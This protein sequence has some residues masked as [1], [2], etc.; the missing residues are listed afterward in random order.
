MNWEGRVLLI[1]DISRPFMLKSM[2]GLSRR[3]RKERLDISGLLCL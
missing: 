2:G 3:I 1:K